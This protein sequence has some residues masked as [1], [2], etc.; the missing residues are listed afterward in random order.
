MLEQI[1]QL[2]IIKKHLGATKFA[3]MLGYRGQTFFTYWQQQEKIP[4]MAQWRVNL[5][6][7]KYKK[8]LNE[9]GI[10]HE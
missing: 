4:H 7:R 8:L 2:A 5:V 1:R 6:L 9:T 10:N 3:E